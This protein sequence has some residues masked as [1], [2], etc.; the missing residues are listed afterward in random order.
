MTRRRYLIRQRRGLLLRVLD[1]HGFLLDAAQRRIHHLNPT[2]LA[3]W[4]LL[5]T[6]QSIRGAAAVLK[7][8]F[9][10]IE[11]SEI[12]RDTRLLIANLLKEGLAERVSQ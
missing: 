8:G 1:H 9:P 10:D 6:P 12:N 11:T 2:A 7:L 5:K 4:R 3:V